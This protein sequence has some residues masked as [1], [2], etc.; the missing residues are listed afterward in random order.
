MNYDPSKILVTSKN[1]EYAVIAKN[2][3]LID[4]KRLISEPLLINEIPS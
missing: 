3:L 4:S 1:V 2:A